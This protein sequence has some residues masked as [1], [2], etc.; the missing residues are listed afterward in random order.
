MS[1]FL[2]LQ[3]GRRPD[4]P[5][6]WLIWNPAES[7]R[8]DGGVLAGADE[9]SQLDAAAARR[10]CYALLPQEQVLVTEVRLPRA[11]RAALAAI[12]FQLEEQL[13]EDPAMLHFA[14]GRPDAQRRYPVAIISRPLICAWRD[15]LAAAPL[16]IQGLYADAQSL[17]PDPG[18]MQ[19][20]RQGSRLLIS[21][22]GGT[23]AI[24]AAELEHWRPLL[25]RQEALEWPQPDNVESSLSQLAARLAPEQA[26]N[27]LQGNYRLQDPD[28][29]RLR[30]WRTPA[31]LA[32]ALPILG[33]ASLGLDNYRLVQQKSA[34]DRQAAEL[35]REALPDVRRMVDPRT[36]MS[37]RLDEL[38]QRQQGPMLLRLLERTL[39]AFRRHASVRLTGL[40]FTANGQALTLS[41][42]AA[43]PDALKGFAKVLADEGL[44]F[45]PA[46]PQNGQSHSSL[47]IRIEGIE[48]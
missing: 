47:Q 10:P 1:E 27:L 15:A 23:L 33:F 48:P 21:G 19:L 24:N 34:L 11:E 31:I 5:I 20:L 36:Q 3:L 22:P 7:C 40:D 13:C 29:S 12:P 41:L 16:R 4:E 2:L 17:M 14:V 8:L 38:R 26:I 45:Q 18:R 39:P 42:E 9:M 43:A 6:E 28:G 30:R 35:F 46:Q 44:R 37:Q 32:L 25:E